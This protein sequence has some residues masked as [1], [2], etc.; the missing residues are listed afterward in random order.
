MKE[1]ASDELAGV[2]HQGAMAGEGAW[3]GEMGQSAK[4]GEPAGVVQG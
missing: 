2:Q 3:L 4:E 1:E